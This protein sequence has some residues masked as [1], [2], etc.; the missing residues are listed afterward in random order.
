MGSETGKEVAFAF[1]PKVEAYRRA[2][3][4][5]PGWTEEAAKKASDAWGKQQAAQWAKTEAGIGGAAERAGAAWSD[6]G[7]K[8]AELAGGPFAKLGQVVF[9]LVPKTSAAA[10]GF[11]SAAAAAGGFVTVAAAGAA[12]VAYG[13]KAVADAGLE[14]EERLRKAGKAGQLDPA[15]TKSLA[16]YRQELD[17]VGTGW[18]RV[19]A[20]AGAEAANVFRGAGVAATELA[21]AVQGAWDTVNGWARAVGLGIDV[22]ARL[23]L[24]LRAVRATLGFLTLGLTEGILKLRD[25]GAAATESAELA[26]GA[27]D[28]TLDAWQSEAEA[29]DALRRDNAKR[30]KAAVEAQRKEE[31]AAAK[32]AREAKQREAE[33]YAAF[34]DGLQREAIEREGQRQAEELD[35]L[36]DTLDEQLEAYRKHD[37]ELEEIRRAAIERE[38]QRQAHVL[39]GVLDSL[40]AQLDAYESAREASRELGGSIADS[41]IGVLDSYSTAW[42]N[43]VE[44]GTKKQRKAAANFAA[45]VKSATIAAVTLQGIQAIAAA[46]ASAPPPFNLPALAIATAEAAARGAAAAAVQVPSAFAGRS[47]PGEGLE[48]RHPNEAV[49]TAPATEQLI[50]LLNDRLSPLATLADGGRGGSGDVW[51]DRK[52]VGRVLRRGRGPEP[53]PGYQPRSRR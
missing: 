9:D 37:E 25:W 44:E 18:D 52:R 2:L 51:L 31:E 32:R 4:Q 12:T 41:T 28:A 20:T 35:K 15:T 1:V 48:R 43:S 33:R 49:I 10:G 16:L 29:E 22:A 45:F 46:A 39:D 38:A 17:A 53:L 13:L 40:D 5:L 6:V 26:K 36:V 34:L 21:T 3:A 14:A 7:K 47:G 27:S 24:T 50:R 8:V 11:A 23:D 30:A 42:S 19:K